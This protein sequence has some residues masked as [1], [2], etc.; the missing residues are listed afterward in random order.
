MADIRIDVIK[1][2]KIFLEVDEVVL[3]E[4]F[5]A[6]AVVNINEDIASQG[7]DLRVSRSDLKIQL[8]A[9]TY[10]DVTGAQAIVDKELE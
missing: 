2:L 6:Y 10:G 1:R 7:M 9:N 5:G 8:N 4:V 3:A